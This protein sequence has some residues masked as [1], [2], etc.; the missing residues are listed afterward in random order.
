MRLCLCD[1]YHLPRDRHLALRPGPLPGVSFVVGQAGTVTR[2]TV[3]GATGSFKSCI[4]KK[5]K[6]IRGLPQLPAPQTFNQCYV[7]SKG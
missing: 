6:R 4:E 3:R 5:F 2:V 7:F 1:R